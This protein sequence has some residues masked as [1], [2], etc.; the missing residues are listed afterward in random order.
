M[1]PKS[2]HPTDMNKNTLRERLNN[3]NVSDFSSGT[4]RRIAFSNYSRSRPE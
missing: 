3:K 1:D 2:H 4:L